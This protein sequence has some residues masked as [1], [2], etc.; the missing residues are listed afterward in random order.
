MTQSVMC[1]FVPVRKN[2]IVY[3]IVLATCPPPPL[4][5]ILGMLKKLSAFFQKPR[6]HNCGFFYV[7]TLSMVLAFVLFF[8]W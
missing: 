7:G 8:I 6:V 2:E 4:V 3:K 5:D 1:Y